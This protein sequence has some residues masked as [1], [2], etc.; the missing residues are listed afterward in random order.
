MSPP[1]AL[2][3]SREHAHCAGSLGKGLLSTVPQ[4]SAPPVQLTVASADHVLGVAAWG[5]GEVEEVEAASVPQWSY[6]RL[7]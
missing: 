4:A 6:V 2:W 7:T 3:G 5:E 1:V